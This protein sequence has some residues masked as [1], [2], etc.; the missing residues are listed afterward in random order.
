MAESGK[1]EKMVIE[2]YEEPDFTSKV[3]DYTFQVNPEN[4]ER[5]VV[6][7]VRDDVQRLSSGDSV[8]G[9]KPADQEYLT[10]TFYVDS[11]GAVP[12]CDDVMANIASLRKLCL[13]V[14]GNIH[15]SN[16]LK[17]RWGTDFLFGCVMEDLQTDFML[18]KPD[19]TPVRAKLVAK[20]TKFTDP[21]T[22][23]KEN[24]KSSPDLTHI[25]TIVDGDNLPM[26]CYKVYGDP[27]YYIQVA[28][29]N[30]LINFNKLEPNQ[31]IIFPRL[32]HD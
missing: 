7:G 5:S 16:Y 32:T 2:A 24:N 20:F 13:D 28:E 17:V 14:N 30:N 19:G 21:A 15:R 23:A 12:D 31:R 26:L 4:Y 8:P 3:D 1:R 27:R 10:L 29:Y 22:K 11:T 9:N 18:F 6:P 25:K